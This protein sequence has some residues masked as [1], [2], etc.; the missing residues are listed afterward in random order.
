MSFHSHSSHDDPGRQH[1]DTVSSPPPPTNA[2]VPASKTV[3][4]PTFSA[5][6][7]A[8]LAAQLS[9][10]KAYIHLPSIQK[11]ISSH[12]SKEESEKDTNAPD[13]DQAITNIP[14]L[15]PLPPPPVYDIVNC[16]TSQTL[17]LVSSLINTIL[18][19]NDRLACP[20]ITLFHSRAIPNISIEAYLTRILQYA[21]FQ[22]EVLLIILLYF[23]R[24]GGGCKPTQVLTN[25]IPKALL[26][27]ASMTAEDVE[28]KTKVE[29][30]DNSNGYKDEKKVHPEVPAE[31]TAM[32]EDE[33]EDEEEPIP[34]EIYTSSSESPVGSKLII[35]SFNIHRLLITSILVASKF[36]SDVFYP[37]VRYAR[38]G[39]LPLSELNQLELEFLFLSQ[40]ELNT[41]ETELQ[42]Y[43]NK[44][45]MYHQR[46]NGTERATVDAITPGKGEYVRIVEK[47]PVVLDSKQLAH[48]H[49]HQQHDS[50]PIAYVPTEQVVVTPRS[51]E[52]KGVVVPGPYRD[53]R[54]II[55][56]DDEVMSERAED[57]VGSP[58]PSDWGSGQSTPVIRSKQLSTTKYSNQRSNKMNLDHMIWPTNEMATKYTPSHY[59]GMVM[60]EDAARIEAEFNKASPPPEE[61]SSEPNPKRKL[62]RLSS[63]ALE[64]TPSKR[65]NVLSR[66][67]T[68]VEKDTKDKEKDNKD[69]EKTPT[70]TNNKNILRP[71]LRKIASFAHR[72]EAPAAAPEPEKPE[73]PALRSHPYLVRHRISPDTS[74]TNLQ[75]EDGNEEM[76][77][78][79]TPTSSE[80][81]HR[82]GYSSQSHSQARPSSFQMK[83][84]PPPYS[85][86][87]N[88]YDSRDRGMRSSTGPIAPVGRYRRQHRSR[89]PSLSSLASELTFEPTRPSLSPMHEEEN[90]MERTTARHSATLA[91]FYFP[92][93]PQSIQRA[94]SS[95][96][97]MHND[98]SGSR[99]FS[100]PPATPVSRNAH[101]TPGAQDDQSRPST[102]MQVG[103]PAPSTVASPS[104]AVD[105]DAMHC[106]EDMPLSR[107]PSKKAVFSEP[108]SAVRP[109]APRAIP[110]DAGETSSSRGA[111]ERVGSGAG[112]SSTSS[113]L[114][115][116]TATRHREETESTSGRHWTTRHAPAP[117]SHPYPPHPAGQYPHI[118]YVASYPPAPSHSAPIQLKV[119]S[120]RSGMSPYPPNTQVTPMWS[121]NNSTPRPATPMPGSNHSKIQSAPIQAVPA[122]RSSRQF[123][124]IRPR[125][126]QATT[127]D[128]QKEQGAPATT[129]VTSPSAAT[130]PMTSSRRKKLSA[131][132]AKAQQ[133]QQLKQQQLR[134]LM[135]TVMAS[136]SAVASPSTTTT[137]AAAP[138]PYRPSF[139]T[140]PSPYTHH[141]GLT[142]IPGPTPNGAPVPPPMIM[143][144]DY[145]HP[146]AAQ[147]LAAA[148]GYHPGG[149]HSHLQSGRHLVHV[150]HPPGTAPA[151][152]F[153][154]I[155]PVMYNNNVAGVR[156]PVLSPT[157]SLPSPGSKSA[158]KSS[159]PAR[160]APRLHRP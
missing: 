34:D 13:Y 149:V 48:H 106:D 159:A 30:N 11:V 14:A 61:Q 141:P 99:M 23:D 115:S 94:Y 41:T 68:G 62:Q 54:E 73:H 117:S 129:E 19:V 35:N 152:L 144:V 77:S 96:E 63:G 139:V 86:Q 78:P 109:G 126:V 140:Y 105:E 107:I 134:P 26:R 64:T 67:N 4:S 46:L 130:A 8:S 145:S 156:P 135:P 44:L 155:I 7:A 113:S 131:E 82:D 69:K 1:H 52:S 12:A 18:S 136:S 111:V 154:P 9:A 112:A 146:G 28:P 5:S 127:E 70:S 98:P 120:P 114:S 21:P 104:S 91:P 80:S 142:V 157:A 108:L 132:A 148:P 16:P 50:I 58:T 87:D 90:A 123:A 84:P 74:S 143:A 75:S 25:T 49:P 81:W 31:S 133:L 110:E 10:K 27:R 116:N 138:P 72:S 66:I 124:P 100:T 53:S 20:K 29:D 92:P 59:S 102:N 93:R 158:G 37:N 121:S 65:V 119:E 137:V 51:T 153:I 95:E 45:L 122:A 22:N 160:I 128:E 32:E 125:T 40:F 39:G 71:L 56:D 15:D 89:E 76:R 151:R 36:S 57:H 2:Y 3:L 83:P 42:S 47:K 24:I 60:D 43:G 55:P 101:G 103:T 147:F 85:G 17:L 6:M 150:Q 88:V 97:P 118:Q 33:E 79:V 38:V